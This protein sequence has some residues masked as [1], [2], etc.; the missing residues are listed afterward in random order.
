MQAQKFGLFPSVGYNTHQKMDYAHLSTDHRPHIGKK[1]SLID[2]R[3]LL[4]K[5]FSY[6]IMNYLKKLVGTKSINAKQ[7]VARLSPRII[8]IV[9]LKFY[10]KPWGWVRIPVNRKKFTHFL[11]YKNSLKNIYFF[12]YKKC[13]SLSIK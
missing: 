7:C 11:R 3:K 10:R 4:A 5:S 9:T 2:F 8:S 12:Y 6:T 1:V 13:H